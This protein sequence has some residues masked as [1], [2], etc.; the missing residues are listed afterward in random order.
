MNRSA[1]L[2][3]RDVV[4]HGCLDED[5][6]QDRPEHDVPVVVDQAAQSVC[7]QEQHSWFV[8]RC[9]MESDS[10]SNLQL[11]LED[12]LGCLWHARRT[13]DMGSLAH[14]TYWEVR[15]WALRAHRDALADLASDVLTKQPL[16]SR[17]EF[18]ALVDK[19]I[20]ELERIRLE[21]R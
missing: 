9:N 1:R 15:R 17:T 18:I 20:E 19:V 13:G 8:L 2:H 10:S 3:S 16:P 21:L 7:R 14:L 6:L 4:G 11:D 5:A 12:V